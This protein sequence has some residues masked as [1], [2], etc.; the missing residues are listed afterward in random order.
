MLKKILN[1]L[2]GNSKKP[3]IDMS[4]CSSDSCGYVS[5]NLS[6]SNCFVAGNKRIAEQVA[7]A[8]KNER[9]NVEHVKLEMITDV[10]SIIKSTADLIGPYDRIFNVFE[11]NDSD[12]VMQIQSFYAVLQAEVDYFVTLRNGYTT[13]IVCTFVDQTAEGK[14]VVNEVAKNFIMG[15]GEQIGRHNIII[16]GM[17]ADEMIDPEIVAKWNCVLGSKYGHI[18]A[19]E[20][21]ELAN[22]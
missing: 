8:L 4:I 22:I 3:V 2:S 17:I 11:I 18:L 12:S 16:N 1:R 10:D 5:G 21:I 6:G 20:V 15:L 7:I 9:A 13:S 14:T 19:G